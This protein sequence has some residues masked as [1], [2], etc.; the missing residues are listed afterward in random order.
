M[1]ESKGCSKFPTGME[2]HFI[3]LSL[4]TAYPCLLLSLPASMEW[5]RR[6]QMEGKYSHNGRTLKEGKPK[7]NGLDD[8]GYCDLLS[9]CI[10]RYEEIFLKSSWLD[11]G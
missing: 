6:K 1:Y 10:S 3:H 2:T 8:N 11:H 9:L 5:P 7:G 4:F